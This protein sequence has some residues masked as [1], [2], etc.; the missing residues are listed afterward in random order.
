MGCGQGLLMD[1]D[2][3]ACPGLVSV[4]ASDHDGALPS[5]TITSIRRCPT[6]RYVALSDEALGGG[7]LTVVTFPAGHCCHL[8][9]DLGEGG[10]SGEERLPSAS[11][12]SS[13][14]A[15]CP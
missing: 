1:G 9:W 13:P 14:V 2:G 8:P 10:D 11:L 6:S 7:S 12:L 4:L 15:G 5:Q 3:P